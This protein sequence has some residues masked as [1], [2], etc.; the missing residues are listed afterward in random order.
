MESDKEDIWHC[1]LSLSKKKSCWCT[2][3]YLWNVW[4]KCYNH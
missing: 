3:N 4:W 2:Q 1:L